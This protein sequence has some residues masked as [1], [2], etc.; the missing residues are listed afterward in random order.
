MAWMRRLLLAQASRPARDLGRPVAA[1][2]AAIGGVGAVGLDDCRQAALQ[3]PIE[4]F[5]RRHGELQAERLLPHLLLA[6]AQEE[7]ATPPV[8]RHQAAA[9]QQQSV[10][11]AGGIAVRPQHVAQHD[12]PVARPPARQHGAGEGLER[13]IVAQQRANGPD[14]TA[15]AQAG[16]GRWSGHG[17]ATRNMKKAARLDSVGRLS[18]ISEA[19]RRQAT[20]CSTLFSFCVARSLSIR[21]T[22]ASSRAS[23]SS[24]AS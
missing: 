4:H 23:R 1:G 14:A 10:Q 22:A 16:D 13:C 19:S 12:Q 11:H 7:N 6:A 8:G 5:E 17:G 18:A 24:A 3:H 20:F 9:Q 15:A 2:D 21:S